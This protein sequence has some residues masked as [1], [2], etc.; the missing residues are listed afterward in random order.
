MKK[1]IVNFYNEKVYYDKLDNGLEVYVIPNNKIKD[2]FVTFTT[3]YGGVN[4]KFKYNNKFISVPNGIAHFLEHKMFEQ[5]DD[6]DPFEFYNKSGTYCNAFTN[7]YNTTYLFAGDN[8][9][10]DNLNYLLDFVQI[11]YFTD[12]NVEKEKGI[13]AQEIKMYDDVP[14]T[15]ILERSVNNLFVNHPIRYS[16]SGTVE[17]IESIT[18]EDLYK[19]YNTFYH[20]KNMFLVISGKVDVDNILN[21][22]KENQSKKKFN[23]LNIEIEKVN[24]PDKVFKKR[25]VIKHNV[26]VPLVSYAIKIPI[27]DIKMDKKK[28]NL[29]I[30]NMFNILFDETSLFYEQMKDKDLL[31]ASIDIDSVD[32]DSHKA[33]I[34]TFRSEKYHEVIKEIDEL[35][36]NIKIDEQDLER[37]KKVDI[38]NLLYIFDDISRTN[39]LFLN[40]K[41]VYD[42]VYL[43]IHDLIKEMNI[44]ELNKIIKDLDLS[45]KTNLIIESRD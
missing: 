41:V 32:T 33:I 8:N 25:E 26:K 9:L 30:T 37:K 21:V 40:N 39:R 34:L 27:K 3:K 15:I 11:P 29:Y 45:N 1:G 17:D 22:I 6:I 20:P 42:D 24:E 43:N 10:E 28:L 5:E 7:Y 44:N 16:I 35:L 23:K 18:K 14:D 2:T 4:Y 31:N 12:E 38:S 13:I 36:K 19:T